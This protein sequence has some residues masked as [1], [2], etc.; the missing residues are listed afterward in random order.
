[1]IEALEREYGG[2]V[3][4]QIDRE[5][6]R[7]A[8]DKLW[9]RAM[10]Y[11]GWADHQA[12]PLDVCAALWPTMAVRTM[13]GLTFRLLHQLDHAAEARKRSSEDDLPF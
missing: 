2:L 13:A 10:L 12:R 8:G 5:G 6:C 7:N 4:L 9:V 1:M 11:S 3:K